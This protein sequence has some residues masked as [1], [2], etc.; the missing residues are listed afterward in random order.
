MCKKL[1]FNTAARIPKY[2]KWVCLQQLKNKEIFK[3]KYKKQYK[4]TNITNITN[5][6]IKK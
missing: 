3:S 4:N 1:I 2:R 5:I 6:N